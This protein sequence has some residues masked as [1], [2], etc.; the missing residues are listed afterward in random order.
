MKNGF[1]QGSPTS[2]IL[3]NYA[4]EFGGFGK[5]N[6]LL[7]YVDD[8][9]ILSKTKELQEFPESPRTRLVGAEIAEKGLG[10]A[11]VFTFLGVE[12][13]TLMWKMTA[14]G[15]SISMNAPRIERQKFLKEVFKGYTNPST[16]A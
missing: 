1:T 9:I 16:K 2:P 7:A 15:R 4:L 11:D 13:N 3:C 8:G 10:Y 12:F 6:G 14:A 5:I